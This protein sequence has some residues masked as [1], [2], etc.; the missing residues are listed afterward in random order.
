MD[1]E[2]QEMTSLKHNSIYFCCQSSELSQPCCNIHSDLIE[3]N[4]SPP[5]WGNPPE[6]DYLLQPVLLLP[7]K[8]RIFLLK[9][10]SSRPTRSTVKDQTPIYYLAFLLHRWSYLRILQQLCFR[11]RGW[12]FRF[13]FFSVSIQ[14]VYSTE[15]EEPNKLQGVIFSNWKWILRTLLNKISLITSKQL[16]GKKNNSVITVHKNSTYRQLTITPKN[17]G[18]TVKKKKKKKPSSRETKKALLLSPLRELK[19]SHF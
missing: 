13:F 2:N 8:V 17:L 11:V 14:E 3:I 16:L 9:P 5:D 15:W 7:L 4:W 19:T 1:E 12:A 6:K 10:S 18:N